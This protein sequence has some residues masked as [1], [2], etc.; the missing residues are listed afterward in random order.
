MNTSIAAAPRRSALRT[1]SVRTLTGA[2]GLG[3]F[4]GA[5]AACSPGASG[6]PTLPAASGGILP[7]LNVSP[8]AS[9]ATQAALAA[10]DQ[11]QAAIGAN[12]SASGLSSDDANSLTQAISALKTAIQTGDQSQLKSALASLT[13]TADTLGPKLSGDAATQLRSLIDLLKA[14]QPSS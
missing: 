4:L 7:S 1:R 6:A 3:L 9:A 13:S 8:I 2:T 14:A 10:L 11:L 12:A 5:L